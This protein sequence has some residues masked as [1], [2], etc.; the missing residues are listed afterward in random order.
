MLG[1]TSKICFFAAVFVGV[2]A[3]CP[4][5]DAQAVAGSNS[6]PISEIVLLDNGRALQGQV[7]RTVDEVHV[8]TRSGSRIILPA[9]R[10]ESIFDSLSDVW[11]H[12]GSKLDSNDIEGHLA[13]FHRCVKHLSL[14]HI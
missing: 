4:S 7:T 6:T 1:R 12:R 3:P 8:R 5:A 13:L 11:T 14:I 10:V 9:K 2:S